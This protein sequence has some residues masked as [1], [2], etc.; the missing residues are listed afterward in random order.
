MAKE[1]IDKIVETKATVELDDELLETVSAG[2][3]GLVIP[4]LY[5]DNE[6]EPIVA[7]GAIA[8]A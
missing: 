4:E 6:D 3:I 5:D 7:V 2:A 8:E 1:I